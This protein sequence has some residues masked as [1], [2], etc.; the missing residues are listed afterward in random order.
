MRKILIIIGIA[1]AGLIVAQQAMAQKIDQEKMDRD[2]EVA[3]TVLNSML[4]KAGSNNL[5][6]LGRL[7]ASQ[8]TKY[9]E[10][11]GV[12]INLPSSSVF[13]FRTL[14]AR[15]NLE[16]MGDSYVIEMP[17]QF[18]E[19]IKAVEEEARARVQVS[20][21]TTENTR[22]GAVV[23][24]SDSLR[25]QTYEK[26]IEAS[27]IF[28]LDYADLIGQLKDSDKILITDNAERS[29]VWTI[30]GMESSSVKRSPLS[31]EI[32]K[33]DLNAYKSGKISRDETLKRIKVTTPDTEMPV[34]QDLELLSTIF[35]RLYRSDLSKTYYLNGRTYYERMHDF[36]VIF[37]MSVYSSQE[38][39]KEKFYM[40]TTG[41]KELSKAD[42]DK[43][44]K[45][46]Y[47]QF[48]KEFKDNI[49]EYGRTIRSLK[50]DEQLIFKVTLTKCAG[51]GIP[52]TLEASVKASVLKE[53]NAGKLDK[54]AAL[55]KLTVKKGPNQ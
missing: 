37:S 7:A 30:T 26:V 19:E 12:V 2:L 21:L 5:F 27:K 14:P 25:A 33:G 52:S 38:M 40:P 34:E 51:C 24:R 6:S 18:E 43:K 46:L 29:G 44:V 55:A 36:G 22:R 45:E 47:P 16:R 32:K 54:N 20:G 13:A 10:G 49:L 4:Q 42:R 23:S 50:D 41:E 3:V 39:G 11:Y 48:E 35:N 17:N 1:V 9:M 15:V 8:N 53:Y 31:V 28:L